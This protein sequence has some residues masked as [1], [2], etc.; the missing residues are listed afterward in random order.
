MNLELQQALADAIKKSDSLP[1]T[2]DDVDGGALQQDN[3]D[4]TVVEP[5]QG[6]EGELPTEQPV[7]QTINVKPLNEKAVLVTLKRGMYRPYIS[8]VNATEEYGAGTVNKHL[9][10]GRDNLV[11]RAVAKFTAVY[12][13][14]NDNTVPW[15]VGQ[16]MLNMMNWTDFTSDLRTLVD[17][18]YAA[19]DTPVSYTH[20]TLPTKRIV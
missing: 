12:T 14:V 19:V 11:K 9:F 6:H 18:A 13:Y 10:D 1:S 15:A 2:H 7:R 5:V 20:L 16:R 8:D 17:D 4:D 3:N